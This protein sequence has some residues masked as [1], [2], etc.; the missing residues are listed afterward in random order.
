MKFRA[1]SFW[2][3]PEKQADLLIE[4][5]DKGVDLAK[6]YKNKGLINK[7][8]S[9]MT[10]ENVREEVTKV[11]K[12]GINQGFYL[13]K[14]LCGRAMDVAKDQGIADFVYFMRSVP[15]MK[16][17]DEGNHYHFEI[18]TKCN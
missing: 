3:S 14:H 2:R 8:L 12:E 7:V 13:S 6:L 4:Q 17:L 15:N 9:K 10:E 16:V 5:Y 18:T 1:T 11:I